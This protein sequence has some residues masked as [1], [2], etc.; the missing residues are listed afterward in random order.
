MFDENTAKIGDFG[1]A[2]SFLNSE[3]EGFLSLSAF[4]GTIEYSPPEVYQMMILAHD[5]HHPQ[6]HN[7]FLN[8]HRHTTPTGFNPYKYDVWS[9][10]IVYFHLIFGDVPQKVI[11]S[12]LKLPRLD[13][14][15]FYERGYDLFFRKFL[16]TRMHDFEV[17]LMMGMLNPDPKLRFSIQDVITDP[18]FSRRLE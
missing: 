13:Q 5:H 12:A 11:P 10:G 8:N 9:L 6:H 3:R 2:K 1:S 18:N 7:R 15:S 17:D 4:S 16:S 14:T